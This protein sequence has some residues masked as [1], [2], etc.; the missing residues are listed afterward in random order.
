M[1]K[2]KNILEDA[3]LLQNFVEYSTINKSP[4]KKSEIYN[5]IVRNNKKIVDYYN[6]KKKQGR[7]I[8]YT[9]RVHGQEKKL[10]NYLET[11][12]QLKLIH[13]TGIAPAD[14]IQSHP[15]EV[16]EYTKGGMLLRL[17][18]ESMGLIKSTQYKRQPDEIYQDIYELIYSALGKKESPA[19]NIFYLNLYEKC[20]ERGIFYKVV[21]RI[22]YIINSNNEITG[23]TDLLYRAMNAFD[24][25]DKRL[26]SD[27]LDTIYKTI[28]D[29]D[30]QVK[31]LFLYRMKIFAENSFERRLENL[32]TELDSKEYEEL[33]FNLRSKYEQIAFRSYCE[34]CKSNQNL[35]LHYS[36]LISPTARYNI[37]AKCSNCNR[38]ISLQNHDSKN[39]YSELEF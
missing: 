34:I 2:E 4:F 1:M 15:V 5:W 33:R 32:G 25:F 23:I 6:K 22:H 27:L 7:H 28:E 21:E 10:D 37:T 19:S 24:I 29:L 13:K 30:E 18:L 12:L 11:L 8:T 26:E 38:T 3:D 14:K 31:K 16:F 20:K 36:D 39:T 17:I 35:E 9:N